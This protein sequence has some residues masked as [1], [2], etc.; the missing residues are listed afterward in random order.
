VGQL[1][2]VGTL[3]GLI[4]LIFVAVIYFDPEARGG[5]RDDRSP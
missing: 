1:I 2:V 3:F 5:P 4:V